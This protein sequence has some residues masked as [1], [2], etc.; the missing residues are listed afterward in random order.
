M[1]LLQ[2]HTL[3]PPYEIVLLLFPLALAAC[4]SALLLAAD[5]SNVPADYKG[6]PYEDEIYQAG[7]QKI[8]GRLGVA[9]YDLAAR[10]WRITTRMR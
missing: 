4:A 2:F 1:P 8:P 7:P 9:Y 5:P 3:F 6:K 10:A